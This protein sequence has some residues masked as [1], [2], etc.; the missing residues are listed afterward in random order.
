MKGTRIKA[1]PSGTNI[2]PE[3]SLSCRCKSKARLCGP[4]EGRGAIKVCI[5]DFQALNK[6]EP[7][8]SH[9]C[10]QCTRLVAD[11]TPLHPLRRPDVAVKYTTTTE[12]EKGNGSGLGAVLPFCE[13]EKIADTGRKTNRT[14]AVHLLGAGVIEE[15][16]K[17]DM[18][19]SRCD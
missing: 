6:S 14:N 17:R 15:V 3:N 2:D 13:F 18:G 19:R 8:E 12:G 9:N 5:Y 7:N 1:W 16:C 10:A 4:P 11:K